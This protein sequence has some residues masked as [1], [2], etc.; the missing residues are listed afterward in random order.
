MPNVYFEEFWLLGKQSNT[1]ISHKSFSDAVRLFLLG[2]IITA[3]FGLPASFASINSPSF[4]ED[5]VTP[6]NT[7]ISTSFIDV[8]NLFN[9]KPGGERLAIIIDEDVRQKQLKAEADRLVAERQRI[10]YNA[11]LIAST[12]YNRF[13]YGYC[14]YY[15]AGKF[16]VTW[17]G[18]AIRWAANARTLGYRVDKIPV[19]GAILQTTENSL[20]SSLGHVT[21]IDRIENGIMYISEMNFVAFNYISYRQ[22]PVNSPLIRA[23][24]HRR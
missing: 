20:G 8:D 5:N 1:A 14:T 16:P 3:T 7:G 19:A 2:I 6:S 4:D 9:V 17:S 22:L 15:V 12:S 21:Y 10:A 23:V 11:K 18:N 13:V 24:I